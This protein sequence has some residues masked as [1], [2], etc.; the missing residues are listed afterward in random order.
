MAQPRLPMHKIRDV[1][2]LAAQGLS[3]RQIGESL[4]I[5]RT[6]V[7]DCLRRAALAG[8]VWPLAG[9]LDDETLEQRLYPPVAADA[10]RPLPDFA[11]VHR[12]LSRAKGVTLLLLWEEYR[13]AKPDGY[14]RSRFCELYHDWVRRRTPVMRQTHRAGEKLFVDYAGTTIPVRDAETG[15][16]REAQLFVAAL[17][18]SSYTFAE[19][20]WTQG[21]ADWI[22]SHTRAFAFLGGVTAMVVSDNLKSGITKACFHEPGVTRS[23][24]EMARHYDTAVVPA[25]VRKP[26]DKAKVEA[27]VQ[28]AT[29]WITAKLRKRTFFSLAELNAAVAECLDTLNAR[30]SRHLGA[31]R[32]ALFEAFDQPALKTLPTEPFVYAEWRLLSVGQDYHVE[33]DGHFYSV[34]HTLIGERLWTRTTATTIEVFRHGRRV[35]AHVRAMPADTADG[36]RPKQATTLSEHMPPSHR[37]YAG[38]TPETAA[39]KAAEVGP[40][41]AA[42]VALVLRDAR[43]PEPGLRAAAGILGLARSYGDERLEAACRRAIAIGARNYSSVASILK[44]NLDRHRPATPTEGPAIVHANI[45]GPDYFH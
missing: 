36:P 11:H 43:H 16:V 5:G 32:R 3:K 45:R 28:V 1:L 44:N 34:P 30:V 41:T 26:R 39:T 18:A 22:A 15:A 37:A 4:G 42:L 6:A 21:L 8:L 24:A 29:R 19:A 12:E 2:R 13:A 7:G 20:T 10:E 17:G 31:S 23:Y 40:E 27:A 25:R 35:A 33:L 9:D 14:S 38:W